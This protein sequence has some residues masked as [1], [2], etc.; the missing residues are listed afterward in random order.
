MSYKASISWLPFNLRKAKNLYL[1][2]HHSNQ[3]KSTIFFHFIL[4][5]T[6]KQNAFTSC[7]I[8]FTQVTAVTNY[9]QHNE[10][11][12]FSNNIRIH[13]ISLVYFSKRN[14]CFVFV[15]YF[16]QRKKVKL[17]KAILTDVYMILVLDVLVPW[18]QNFFMHNER[19]ASHT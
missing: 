3:L 14:I 11:N 2:F 13:T 19:K 4:F 5:L 10:Q 17:T 1:N 8:L 12:W 15:I 7:P 6:L 16:C 18:Q 9:F